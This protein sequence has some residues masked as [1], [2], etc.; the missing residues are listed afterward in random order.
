MTTSRFAFAGLM[1]VTLLSACSPIVRRH[2]YT[3]TA[4]ELSAIIPGT[5]TRAAALEAL[6]PPTTS[7]VQGSLYYVASQFETIGPLRPKETRREVVA[8]TVNTREVVTGVERYGLSDGR[9]VPLSR[10]VTSDNVTD[11]TFLRQL[12]GNL[13][14]FDATSIIGSD[15]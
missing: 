4:D 1:A 15:G 10:R 8:I 11:T 2:G 12:M 7:G 13:G 5:T 14:R 6:P 9:V 3:P